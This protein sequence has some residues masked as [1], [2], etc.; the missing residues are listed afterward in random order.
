M[1]NRNTFNDQDAEELLGML[2]SGKGDG[3]LRR[4]ASPCYILQTPSGGIAARSGTTVSSA[5]CTVY[6]VISNTLTSATI[7]L[8]VYNLSTKAVAG[9]VYIGAVMMGGVLIAVW[10]DC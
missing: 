10:E 7:T 3:T 1:V 4:G 5:N 9:S 6:S 2:G 8:P